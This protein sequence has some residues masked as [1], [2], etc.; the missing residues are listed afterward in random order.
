MHT[1]FSRIPNQESVK[2]VSRFFRLLPKSLFAWSK[3]F[4]DKSKAPTRQCQNSPLGLRQLTSLIFHFAKSLLAKKVLMTA[5]RDLVSSNSLSI[6]DSIQFQLL[7]QR[8]S[9]Y[10]QPACRFTLV[11]TSQVQRFQYGGLFHFFKWHIWPYAIF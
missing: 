1:E 4:I 9:G 2:H 7:M 6:H 3:T 5:Q 8:S 10:A 11:A